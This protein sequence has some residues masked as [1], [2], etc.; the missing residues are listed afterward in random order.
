VSRRPHRPVVGPRHTGRDA[1][2]SGRAGTHGE[3]R[4]DHWQGRDT[5]GGTH[6]PVV[7]PRH[8]GRDAPTNGRAETHG[9]GRADQ[10]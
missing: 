3:G 2:T 4:T 10:W 1:P 9:E 7:G 5:R 6:R 8:T